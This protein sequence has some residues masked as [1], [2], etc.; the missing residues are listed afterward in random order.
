MTFPAVL[1][2]VA[3]AFR[4]GYLY[5]FHITQ[6]AGICQP[7]GQRI[8]SEMEMAKRWIENSFTK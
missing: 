4:R 3:T 2:R 1:S 5:L 6:S 7:S 8:D